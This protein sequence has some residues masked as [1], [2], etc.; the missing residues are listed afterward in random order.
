[1]CSGD[2]FDPESVA[3]Q[4]MLR[5]RHMHHYVR[6]AMSKKAYEELEGAVEGQVPLLPDGQL[7]MNQYDV[8]LVQSGF[9]GPMILQPKEIGIKVRDRSLKSILIYSNF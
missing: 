1:M 9:I 5:V 7:P 2:I 4:S 8:A 6:T 3:G